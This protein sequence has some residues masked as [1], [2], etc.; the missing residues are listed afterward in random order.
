M[1]SSSNS[2]GGWSGGG[3]AASAS[4]RWTSRWNSGSGISLPII[5]TVSQAVTRTSATAPTIRTIRSSNPPSDGGL[6]SSTISPTISA[7]SAAARRGG[8]R[9]SLTYVR[10]ERG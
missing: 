6:M 1:T 4:L 3:N 10:L 8:P 2:L 5:A 9:A 7:V